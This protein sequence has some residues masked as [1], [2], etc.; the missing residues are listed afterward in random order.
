MTFDKDIASVV[1]GV[2]GILVSSLIAPVVGWLA[3]S[4]LSL[5][6]A[7]TELDATVKAHLDDY[8]AFKLQHRDNPTRLTKVEDAIVGIQAAMERNDKQFSAIMD[9]LEAIPRLTTLMEQYSTLVPRPEMEARMRAAEDRLRQVESD[10]R[11][12]RK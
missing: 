4:G 8:D 9:K 7:H 11:E 2:V 3:K 6:K 12:S 1:I 10:V 5:S